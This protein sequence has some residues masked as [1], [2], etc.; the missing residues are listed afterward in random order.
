MLSIRSIFLFINILYIK[1]F[2]IARLFFSLSSIKLIS[3]FLSNLLLS[4]FITSFKA[5]AKF[6]SLII[7]FNKFLYKL[8]NLENTYIFIIILEYISSI[9]YRIR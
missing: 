3:N 2:L 8:I 4:N 9:R 6:N 1:Y 7:L 5:L